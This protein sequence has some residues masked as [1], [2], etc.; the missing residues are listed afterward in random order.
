MLGKPFYVHKTTLSWRG[1][2]VESVGEGQGNQ[3]LGQG[4]IGKT[5]GWMVVRISSHGANIFR[6]AYLPSFRQ[7]NLNLS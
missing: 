3:M 4:M 7:V 5:F 2:D 1:G 6:A